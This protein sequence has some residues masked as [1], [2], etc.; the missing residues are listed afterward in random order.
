MGVMFLSLV[1]VL[2]G[3]FIYMLPGSKR[4]PKEKQLIENFYAHR[5]AFE[6]LHEMLVADKQVLAVASWGIET[7]DSVP[8]RVE[9]GGNFPIN[10]YNDYLSLL[11]ETG[12]TRVFRVNKND[13]D[14]IGVSVWAAGWAGDSRHIDIYW[15]DQQPADQVASLD[16][17]YQT[18]KPRHPVFRHIDGNWY[19]WADW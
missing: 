9:A 11:K 3:L 13:L 2:L 17:Y 19:L 10:R 12:G 8:H 16:N 15:T 5:A 18:P 1:A 7:K 4:P 14:L 6:R